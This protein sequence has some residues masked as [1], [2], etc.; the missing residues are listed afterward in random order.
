MLA[1]RLLAARVYT[2]GSKPSSTMNLQRQKNKLEFFKAFL[3]KVKLTAP[4]KI[5]DW[6]YVP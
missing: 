4:F 6:L 2:F 5:H 1:I 3:S